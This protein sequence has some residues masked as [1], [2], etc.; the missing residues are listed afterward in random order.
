M[1]TSPAAGQDFGRYHLESLLGQG[2]MGM[3]FLATDTLLGRRVALKVM[4]SNVADSEDFLERFHREANVLARLD[5]PHITKIFDHGEHEGVPYIATQ[6]LPGGDLRSLL[7][8][9]GRMPM[10]LAAAV[11]AQIAGALHEAHVAGVIHRDIKPANVLVRDPDQLP[12]QVCL[13]DFGIAQTEQEG[14]T[15]AG[16]VAGTWA[17]LA[18]ERSM[19][20]HA[21]AAS[22]TYALGCLFWTTITGR[23][24]YAGSD[25]QIAMAHRDAPVPRFNGTDATA[26]AVNAFMRRAMAKDAADRFASAA[27]MQ[28][29]LVELAGA[30]TDGFDPADVEDRATDSLPALTRVRRR[31]TPWV[32]GA[33]VGALVVASAVAGAVWWTQT[34]TE[35]PADAGSSASGEPSK[36][37]AP[38]LGDLDGRTGT[39]RTPRTSDDDL[40]E[41]DSIVGDFDGDGRA[42]VATVYRVD[43]YGHTRRLTVAL[44]RGSHF[45]R[46]KEW[47]RAPFSDYAP[48]HW[49]VG[50]FDGDGDDD[51]ASVIQAD[52]P[53]LGTTET[54]T[55]LALLRSNGKRFSFGTSAL[56]VMDDATI[57]AIDHDGDGTASVVVA[58]ENNRGQSAPPQIVRLWNLDRNGFSPDLQIPDDSPRLTDM[59]TLAVSDVNG[60]GRPDVLVMPYGTRKLQ[61]EVSLGG[62]QGFEPF[63]PWATCDVCGHLP[64]VFDAIL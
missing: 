57:A 38:V 37:P 17:Y 34:R 26:L 11:C 39:I 19:G 35:D 6:Y 24:P 27:A 41:D 61:V 63:T 30:H 40:I 51:L 53:F 4:S 55:R 9:R 8:Q 58:E 1:T 14:L 5:S 46:P 20:E 12:P 7:H 43:R 28:T 64:Q 16:G 33:L 31:R 44:N 54:N 59:Q 36:E 32:V 42:D 10:R 22:D 50:D 29:A 49:A 21:T 52:H 48:P 23:P 18:P 47:A 62:A 13:C 25:V 3:V 60:D 56:R 45:T 15:V 2:G